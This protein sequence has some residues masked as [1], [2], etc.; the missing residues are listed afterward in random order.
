MPPSAI[1]ASTCQ[2][3]M[4]CP[5]TSFSGV[6]C[7]LTQLVFNYSRWARAQQ[8]GRSRRSCAAYG[9]WDGPRAGRAG[10]LQTLDS[11]RLND[12][13]SRLERRDTLRDV[14]DT[15]NATVQSDV[16]SPPQSGGPAERTDCKGT[17]FGKTV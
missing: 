1:S 10:Q 13:G 15:T 5:T 3:P 16:F 8:V 9:A 7:K 11:L 4:R 2:E 6:P 14:R 12:P 17:S